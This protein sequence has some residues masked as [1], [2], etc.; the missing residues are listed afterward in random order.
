MKR[1]SIAAVGAAFAVA[2]AGCE[3]EQAQ[4]PPSPEVSI[5]QQENVPI[6]HI[7]ARVALKYPTLPRQVA[8]S[9]SSDSN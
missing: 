8:R 9:G 5:T 1:H 7:D 4:A 6:S 2:T 3:T